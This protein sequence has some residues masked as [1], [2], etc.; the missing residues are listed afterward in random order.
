MD[1]TT[2]GPTCAKACRLNVCYTRSTS[3]LLRVQNE[4]PTLA[5]IKDLFYTITQEY[6][7]QGSSDSAFVAVDEK[8]LPKMIRET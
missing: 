3:G 5:F 4:S 6:Q 8:M 1:I 2:K 7:I